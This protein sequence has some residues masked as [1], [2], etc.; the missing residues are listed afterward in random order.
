MRSVWPVLV[1]I[2]WLAGRA[3]AQAQPAGERASLQWVEATLRAG[4]PARA[5]RGLA[6]ALKRTPTPALALRY[7]ELA[8]PLAPPS[9]ERARGQREKAAVLLL[10]VL[11]QASF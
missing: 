6:R 3:A 10:Q 1:M 11:A 5:L 7:A 8:L 4:D 9:S 2:A